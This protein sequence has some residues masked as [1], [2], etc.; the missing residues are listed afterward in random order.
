MAAINFPS[1]PTNA[2]QYTFNGITYY[3]D[4]TVGAWLTSVVGNPIIT[5]TANV[6]NTAPASA[7]PGDLWFNTDLSKMF[8]YYSDGDTSQWVEPSY[9][10]VFNRDA[11]LNAAFTVANSAYGFANGVSTNTTASFA[12]ANTKLSNGSI[13]INGT[14]RPLAL[15]ETQVAPTISANTLTIDCS[16]GNIFKV[17]LNSNITTLTFSNVPAANSGY[18]LILSLTAD[19]T[20]RTVTWGSPVKWPSATAPTLTSTNGKVDTF[21]LMTWDNGTSW[22]GF[23]GGQNA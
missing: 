11:D 21:V 14:V 16:A 6:G 22:F 13:M 2:Q 18:G 20:A 12:A 5:S 7:Y 9:S 19:G 23:T 4:S 1:S 17:N 10:T 3:Y 15:S 8:V